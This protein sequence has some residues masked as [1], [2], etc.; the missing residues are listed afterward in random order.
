LALNYNPFIIQDSGKQMNRTQT[1]SSRVA[2]VPPWGVD[3]DVHHQTI[4]DSILDAVPHAVIG[5]R[6]RTI[7]FANH[8][9]KNVFGWL[10]D[11]LIGR[12]T[13]MLYG[14]EEDYEDIGR[15]FYSVLAE[16]RTFSQEYSCRRKDGKDITCMVSAS[17]VG[18]SLKNRMIVV[19]YE[20]ISDRKRAEAVL[21]RNQEELA[22]I[23]QER[24][25][26]L[27]K[28]YTQLAH[29]VAMHAA[30]EA[31]R[32]HMERQLSDIIEF[33]PDATFAIDREGK[34]IIW[35]QAIE[36]MT[37]VAA[38]DI[39]GK[40][41]FEYALPFYGKRRPI[42]LD[43]IY[44]SHEE[45]YRDYPY[46]KKEKD[47]L[48]TETDKPLVKGKKRVLSGKAGPLYD[49]EGRIIGAIESIRDVTERRE[50]EEA[51]KASEERYRLFIN[52]TDDI[53][54]LKDEQRRYI[55]INRAATIFLGK[56]EKEIIGRT[57]FELM[58]E[59]TACVFRDSDDRAL[60]ADGVFVSE[61]T[62]GD[63]TFE[64]RKF[65][66]RLMDGKI[67]IGAY[68]RE[69]T[70]Q[71]QLEMQLLQAQKMEAI[72]TLAGG[73]AHDFNNL[74]MGIQ[75]HVSLME[76]DI[77]P[78]HRHFER[79]LGIQEQVQSG[80]NLTR[81]LLGFARG[82]RYEIRPT[83]INQLIRKTSA[84]FGRTKKEIHIQET[85]TDN[86]WTVNVDQTQ[87][88]QVFMNLYVN[89]WQAM[90]T[91]GKLFLETEN[92]IIEQDSSESQAGH[93]GKYVKISVRDTGVGM[94]DKTRRR[95]FEPFFTTKE[96]GRGTGLGLATV[97]GIVKGHDGFIDVSSVAGHGSSFL[98]YLPAV[99]G[100]AD[101]EVR[102]QGCIMTGCETILLVDDEAIIIDVTR[103]ILEALGYRVLTASGG[104]E[105]VSVCKEATDRIAVVIL[106]M[107]MP[108][109]GGGETFDRLKS[110][111]PEVKVILS[112]GY[113]M[114][115]Q[116]KSIIDKGV[117]AFLQKPYRVEELSM[118][119]REV[120]DS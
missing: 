21:A 65:S 24:T 15:K 43:L 112:S 18:D 106:D 100:G 34:V 109:M 48:Q 6:N 73:I 115:A 70:N 61:E 71:K 91:G 107:V 105:A 78:A 22:I 69:I 83:D 77:S 67:G 111:H 14:K 13:R 30:E 55:F 33:L 62:W 113:S 37:G 116:A 28:L 94:D 31:S 49:S 119:I 32:K 40:G 16:R 26:E 98:I 97:Y 23:V 120:L 118:K 63:R 75:G 87:M 81:Q 8:A 84:M 64:S 90:P 102:E 19:T 50:S 51:L 58:S 53:V 3:P 36:E 42:L 7:I 9:V 74:L 27:H 59:D 96:M 104:R 86:L 82:G 47:V 2:L 80:A 68:L 114:N 35:N 101:P 12:S 44:S 20:D 103:D 39:L 4:L 76:M 41:N 17:R 57:D 56:Q 99:E 25:L 54:Y 66:I 1:L 79:I 52:G 85:F 110:V 38:G 11:D 95:I 60:R 72:G 89:A 93:V 117:N 5:L 92:I 46:L 29:E 108:E 10:P 88:E 45:V